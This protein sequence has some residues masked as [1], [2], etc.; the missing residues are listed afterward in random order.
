MDNGML[1]RREAIYNAQTMIIISLFRTI[2]F[3]DIN[4]IK[5]NV[6]FKGGWLIADWRR[7]ILF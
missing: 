1:N 5:I 2:N 3:E 4:K 6:K 7:G